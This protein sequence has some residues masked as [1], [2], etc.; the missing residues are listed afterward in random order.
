MVDVSSIAAGASL[1]VLFGFILV[2]V[3]ALMLL[4]LR[5]K[6]GKIAPVAIILGA[7]LLG[8][9][10]VAS[11]FAPTPGAATPPPPTA[12]VLTQLAT[13]PA[14]VTGETFNTV[15]NTLTVDLVYNKTA[16]EFK[17]ASS[18]GYTGSDPAYIQFPMK[19]V[20]QDAINQTF[21]FPMTVATIPTAAS[22][23]ATP[24][25]YSFVGYTPATSTNPGT[26]QLYFSAGTLANQKPTVS[27]PSVTTNVLTD[28]V[29]VQSFNSATST[30]HI[31]L[32]GSNS[33][34]AP[35]LFAEAIQNYTVYPMTINIGNSAPSVMTINFLLL[36][37]YA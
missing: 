22:L 30:L 20:R 33:T 32:G 36:G 27:A 35:T 4:A 10:F 9:G 12:S 13:A 11:A 26:W 5:G 14:L 29:P 21:S 37:W 6:A 31:A 23:G 15:T 34:S 7:V 2:V 17:V 1:L 16:N 18:V 8:G 25:V 3:G 28:P 24:T 19:L